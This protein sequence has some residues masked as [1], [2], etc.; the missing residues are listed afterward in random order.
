MQT[1]LPLRARIAGV[2]VAAAVGAAVLVTAPGARAAGCADPDHPGGDW[3]QYSHDL[4][5]SRNQPAETTIGPDEASN[6]VLKN[7]YTLP[8]SINHDPIVVDGC[9]YIGTTAGDVAALNADTLDVVWTTKLLLDGTRAHAVNSSPTV[10]DGKV[11]LHATRGGTASDLR[12]VVLDQTTGAIVG[13]VNLLDAMS[14]SG[15]NDPYKYA[16]NGTE[17]ISSPKVFNGKIFSG[18]SGAGAESGNTFAPTPL[19]QASGQTQPPESRLFF[20]GIYFLTDVATMSVE[21]WN[22]TIPQADFTANRYGYAGG[23]IWSSP[24][25][26]LTENY[27]YVGSGNPFSPREHQNTNAILKIDVDPT[28]PTYGDIVARYKGNSD[29][30]LDGQTYKPYCEVYVDVFVCETSDFDFGASPQLITAP[31]G[32]KLVGGH[33]KAG[34][35]HVAKRD[36]DANGAMP[37]VWR[38]VV[39]VPFGWL[40]GEGTASYV[41]GAVVVPGGT[42]GLM[43]KFDAVSGAREWT[44]PIADGIHFTSVTTANGVAY[45]VDTRGFLSIYDIE[46]GQQLAARPLRAELNEAPAPAAS[47]GHSVSVARNQ[48]Y[49]PIG[50]TLVVYQA[51]GA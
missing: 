10:Q 19:G 50:G 30:Y 23:G 40:G 25:V 51:P 36:H 45:T 47:T 17:L 3:A 21:K 18:V 7:R 26:D 4:D 42:P 29:L 12:V 8:G 15:P 31:D 14:P 11:Y 39:G 5:N 33:Q 34:L 27:A 38:D 22:F 28:R 41:D 44:S 32:T 1:R 13:Q 9:V 24:A 35:Y 49:V 20:R 46:T 16:K 48:V 6:L 37:G 43:A 2:A